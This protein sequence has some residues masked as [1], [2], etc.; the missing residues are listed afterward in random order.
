LKILNSYLQNNRQIFNK[1]QLTKIEEINKILMNFRIKMIDE[2]SFGKYSEIFFSSKELENINLL[3][4]IK[5]GEF[6]EDRQEY[7]MKVKIF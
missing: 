4:L 6:K 2:K 7:W 5:N 1:F 3:K